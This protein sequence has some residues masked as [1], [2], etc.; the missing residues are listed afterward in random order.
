ME[1]KTKQR[2]FFFVLHQTHLDFKNTR[3]KKRPLWAKKKMLVTGISPFTKIIY[4]LLTTEIV[5]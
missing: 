5:I 2:T 4:T 1:L 3:K